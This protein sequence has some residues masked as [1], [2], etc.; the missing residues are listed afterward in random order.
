MDKELDLA[1]PF[2]DLRDAL[3]PGRGVQLQRLG[4][5]LRMKL[6]HLLE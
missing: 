1:S 4:Q 2:H 6:E 5:A 3:K